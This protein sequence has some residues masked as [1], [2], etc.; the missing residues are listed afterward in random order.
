ME[1]ALL[2]VS[3]IDGRYSG[4]TKCLSEY[5]S[6]ECALIKCILTPLYRI[7]FVQVQMQS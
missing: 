5:F 4:K 1:A 6:G 7:R 3:P 2:A